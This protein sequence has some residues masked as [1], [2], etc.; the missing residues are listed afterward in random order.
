[1]ERTP[2]VDAT[3]LAVDLGN[4]PGN[5]NVALELE[6]RNHDKGGE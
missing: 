5:D 4:C 6:G 2:F 3:W 1:M